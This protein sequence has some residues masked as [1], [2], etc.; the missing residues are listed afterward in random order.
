M[1][2]E[3]AAPATLSSAPGD[4]TSAATP[5]LEAIGI[6]KAYRR[7]VWPARR[8]HRVSWGSP[9]RCSS[10]VLREIGF[11][12]GEGDATPFASHPRCREPC[13]GCGSQPGNQTPH[14]DSAPRRAG[15]PRPYPGPAQRAGKPPGPLPAA[16]HR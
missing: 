2:T 9:W 7:G 10:A 16:R 14:G 1:S 12:D 11:F 4:G 13:T 15:A 3:T 6:E 5:P 8:E